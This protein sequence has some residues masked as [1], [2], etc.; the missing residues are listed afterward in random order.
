MHT[1]MS[2]ACLQ[3]N[4]E[5]GCPVEITFS[6]VNDSNENATLDVWDY[7]DEN[8]PVQIGE[9]KA[10]AVGERAGFSAKDIGDGTARVR[11][12]KTGYSM[13]PDQSVANDHAPY[14]IDP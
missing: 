7:F 9:Q 3:F 14:S 1:G 2:S 13:T 4:F 12:K 11:W 8:S 5:K 6:I 10:L